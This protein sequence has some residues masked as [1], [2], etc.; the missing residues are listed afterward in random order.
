MRPDGRRDPAAAWR[1]RGAAPPARSGG[2]PS[3]EASALVGREPAAPVRCAMRSRRRSSGAVTVR[4]SGAAGMGK[5]TVAHRPRRA[6]RG[7]TAR[8][9]CVGAPTSAS[10][11]LTK[12]VDSVIDALTRYLMRRDEDGAPVSSRRTSA[13]SATS[14]P[15]LASHLRASARAGGDAADDLPTLRRRA[16][17]ALRELLATLARQRAPRPLRG[18]RAVRRRRQRRV[19]P[20]GDTAPRSPPLLLLMT[21]REKTCGG[22]PVSHRVARPA[23]ARGGD[24]RD[25]ETLMGRSIS[26]RDSGGD[27]R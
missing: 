24:V 3:T 2:V 17:V 18:R 25:I 22:Q 15:R 9:Y 21:Y 19:A 20:R 6:R 8:S 4:V 23:L 12:P 7:S 27:W 11:S 13:R 10:P 14:V 16:F 5:S 1:S 26:A